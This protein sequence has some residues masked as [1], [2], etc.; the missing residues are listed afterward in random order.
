MSDEFRWN[1]WNL[2]HATSHGVSPLEAEMVV[3]SARAPYPEARGDN[4]WAVLGRGSSGRLI[5]V[6]Y[7]VDAEETLYVIHARPLT[8]REKHKYRRRIR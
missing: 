6:I 3:R 8:D 7:V 1:A 2:E 4:K 5:Q